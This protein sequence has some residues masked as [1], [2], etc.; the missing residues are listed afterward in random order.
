MPISFPP[1]SGGGG[2]SQGTADERYLRIDGDQGNSDT[3]K[4]QAAANAGLV[5][6]DA[7]IT[8]PTPTLG[9][10]TIPITTPAP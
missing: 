4:R 9:T 10:G 5:I 3:E 8:V 7:E 1:G 6:G 2:L